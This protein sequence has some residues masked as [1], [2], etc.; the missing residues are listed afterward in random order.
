MDLSWMYHPGIA[1]GGMLVYQLNA[2]RWSALTSFAM[3]LPFKALTLSIMGL[4][5]EV[6]FAPDMIARSQWFLIQ[7]GIVILVTVALTVVRFREI[8]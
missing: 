7:T 8:K 3:L 5:P 1:F 2:M 6:A 4:N